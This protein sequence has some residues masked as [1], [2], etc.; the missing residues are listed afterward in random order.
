[1]KRKTIFILFLVVGVCTISNSV[2]AQQEEFKPHGKPIAR[3]FADYFLSQ[4]DGKSN[5]GFALRRG[6]LGYDYRFTEQLSARMLLDVTAKSNGSDYTAHLRDAYLRYKHTLFTVSVGQTAT[7]LFNLQEATWGRRYV[8]K[9]LQDLNGFGSSTDLG[10]LLTITPSKTV[11]VDVGVF[12]G[13]GYRTTQKDSTLRV[14]LGATFVPISGFKLR[15]YADHLAN[16]SGA[17]PQ[18]EAQS[19]Y[20]AFL[21]YTYGSFKLSAEYNHQKNKGRQAHANYSGVSIYGDYK[22]DDKITA[23]ARWDKVSSK[24]RIG[25]TSDVL[26]KSDGSLY[27]I[28]GEY[29]CMKG[30]RI[31]PNI[32]HYIPLMKE[33]RTTTDFYLH[34]ELSF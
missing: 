5:T 7:A 24:N 25:A 2:K 18:G 1:M 3:V 15:V 4:Y 28:G 14:S 31:S 13:E 12:N 21:S 23:F 33:G 26:G 16:N 17:N 6:M 32:Q 29:L 30:I 11:Q 27:V 20:N 8:Q 9:S 10:I 19:T 22:V 34:L